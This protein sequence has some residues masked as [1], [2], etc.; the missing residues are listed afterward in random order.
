M[1]NNSDSELF[2]ACLNPFQVEDS[3]P[4]LLACKKIKSLLNIGGNPNKDMGFV[5]QTA[6]LIALQNKFIL[7]DTINLLIEN[8]GD[9]TK[10]DNNGKTAFHY[11]CENKRPDI[12]IL[13]LLLKNKADP[14]QIDRYGNTCLHLLLRHGSPTISAV[15]FLLEKGVDHNCV[16]DSTSTL[17][18][19]IAAM[20]DLGIIELLIGTGAK[21]AKDETLFD[22]N[23]ELA[24]RM[25]NTGYDEEVKK[26][27][28]SYKV[29]NK[30]RA[31][32]FFSDIYTINNSLLDI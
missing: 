8:G 4:S 10:V 23:V 7:L 12:E 29:C 15:Q 5:G 27:L 13:K 22:V 28:I 17:G 6:M 21:L 26:L 1:F 25:K 11:A 24:Y 3:F 30:E 20:R 31:V 9:V 19:S 16:V 32:S 2:K 18:A 14:M